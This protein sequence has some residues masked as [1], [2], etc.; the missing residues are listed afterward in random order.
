MRIAAPKRGLIPV[1]S[2]LKAGRAVE[3]DQKERAARSPFVRLS[4]FG[5][6]NLAGTDLLQTI[7]TEVTHVKDT[8]RD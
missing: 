2:P 3:R 7:D 5:K 6:V 8:S 1:F 4:W